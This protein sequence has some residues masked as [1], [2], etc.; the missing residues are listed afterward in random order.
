MPAVAL[1]MR[2]EATPAYW[3]HVPLHWSWP[4]EP[5]SVPASRKAVM[6]GLPGLLR[7]AW[8]D[9]VPP[10]PLS[11]EVMAELTEAFSLMTSEL[12]TNA[13][14][15]APARERIVEVNLWRADGMIWLAVSDC[16][17]AFTAP[18]P[19]PADPMAPAFPDPDSDHGRGLYLVEALSDVWT[20]ALRPTVG[21]SVLAGLHL[22]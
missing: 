10:H 9:G 20:V 11:A 22:P 1:S 6:E 15:H 12:V 18:R 2:V 17:E 19:K 16:G 7:P 4:A 13:I 5:A 14:T 8:P 3:P 21:K